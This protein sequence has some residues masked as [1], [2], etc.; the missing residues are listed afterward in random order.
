MPLR[1]GTGLF[2]RCIARCDWLLTLAEND[3]LKVGG[4]VP[5]PELRQILTKL[6]AT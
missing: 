6:R 2:K 3:V 1:C 5:D 4:I